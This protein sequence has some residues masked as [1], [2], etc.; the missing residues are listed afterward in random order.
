MDY[1][2][3]FMCLADIL[4]QSDFQNFLAIHDLHGFPGIK[5]F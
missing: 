1:I 5:T 3:S 4:I 2:Y